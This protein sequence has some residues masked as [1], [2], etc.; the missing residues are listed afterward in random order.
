MSNNSFILT[1]NGTWIDPSQCT[2]A[3]C[4]LS[5]ATVDYDPNLGGNAFF[6]AVFALLIFIHLFMGIKYKTWG[7]FVGM[8]GGLALEIVGYVARVMMSKNPWESNPFLMYVKSS[9]I[10][11]SY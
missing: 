10:Q 8:V 11:G 4:S 3:L 9:I 6:L 2:L 5:Q 7:Y 1:F